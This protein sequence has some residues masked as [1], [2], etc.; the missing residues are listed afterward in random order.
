MAQDATPESG[1]VAVGRAGGVD[2]PEAVCVLLGCRAGGRED[3][4]GAAATDVGNGRRLLP[5]FGAGEFLVERHDWSLGRR[6]SVTGATA[7]RVEAGAAGRGRSLGDSGSWHSGGISGLGSAEE[8]TGAAAAGVCVAVLRHRGVWL[9]DGV[10]R[11]HL[12]K[13][14][15]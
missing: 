11:R 6:V 13:F 8:V 3:V 2:S 12:D 4:A 7:A 5:N 15:L 14:L 10:A 9:G 1:A